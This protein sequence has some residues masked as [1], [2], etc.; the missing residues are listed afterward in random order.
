MAA[1][2]KQKVEE[3]YILMLEDTL[4]NNLEMFYLEQMT[5]QKLFQN[6]KELKF[7]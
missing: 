2:N 4:L 1:N 3:N 5:V 7:K 6:M